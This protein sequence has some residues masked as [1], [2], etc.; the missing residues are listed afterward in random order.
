GF[1]LIWFG[2]KIDQLDLR[3]YSALVGI[4][5]FAACLLMAGVASTVML[6]L[7]I[8]LLRLTG[9]GLMSHIAMTS[10]AR[11]F[12]AGRGRAISIA[13]FGFPAGEALFPTIAVLSIAVIGW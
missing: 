5:F 3:L 8:F 11:Y 10:M 2:R 13:S 12:E 4:T 9:Q 6:G 7:A 1:S